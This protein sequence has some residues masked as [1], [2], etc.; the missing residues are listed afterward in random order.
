MDA[1]E[2]RVSPL[3]TIIIEV[4]LDKH[5]LW[6]QYILSSNELHLSYFGRHLAIRPIYETSRLVCHSLICEVTSNSR[7]QFIFVYRSRK[8]WQ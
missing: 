2:L 7:I 1:Q 3:S 8:R 5:R 6:Q 4:I